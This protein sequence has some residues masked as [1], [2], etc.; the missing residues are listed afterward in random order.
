M[1]TD[2]VA[3]ID[4]V[5]L[6]TESRASNLAGVSVNRL[7]EWNA[8]EVVTPTY[9]RKHNNRHVNFYDFSA[10][11][12][13]LVAARLR[14]RISFQ[15]IQLVLARIKAR[16]YE[17]PLRQITFATAG[18]EL[19]FQ[20]EDGSWESGRKPGQGV[21]KET[22]PLEQ[23]KASI[24]EAAAVDR[25]AAVGETDRRRGVQG[26]RP[27]F[28]GTRIPVEAV[29]RYVSAGR[30]DS[31]ILAAYPDLDAADIAYARASESATA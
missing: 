3:P 20:N 21:I 16:G 7:R 1:H 4:N 15:Q 26:S 23:I 25:S 28:K 13:L 17:K 18:S 29:Q 8:K 2:E 12:E 19:Y 5:L 14:D 31:E 11:V 10:M 27:T 6:L 22:I 24:R 30:T 9:A